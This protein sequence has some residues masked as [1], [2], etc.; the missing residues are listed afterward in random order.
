MRLKSLITLGIVVYISV[1]YVCILVKTGLITKDKNIHCSV[2]KRMRLSLK[3]LFI[4]VYSFFR[5]MHTNTSLNKEFKSPF[6]SLILKYMTHMPDLIDK[7][8]VMQLSGNS[9]LNIVNIIED[10]LIYLKVK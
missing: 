2:L 3:C 10:N 5:I 1:F 8:I 9:M 6:K 4:V 7:A